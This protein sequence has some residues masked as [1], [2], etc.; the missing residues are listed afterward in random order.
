MTAS[1]NWARS[2]GIILLCL[3][4]NPILGDSSVG[5]TITFREGGSIRFA[6]LG[7][8]GRPKEV[9]I[10][11]YLQG[12][13][14]TFNLSEVSQITLLDENLD[15]CYWHGNFYGGPM[16]VVNRKGERLSL[17]K[18]TIGRK[19]VCK[20]RYVARSPITNEL[21]GEETEIR[22]RVLRIELNL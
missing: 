17:T 4:A 22:K 2:S 5:G 3:Y 16:E 13:K 6:Y 19:D 21:K 15:Y 7:T 10:E 11:G 12:Q 14:L 8:L 18:A 1:R 9:P 20:L